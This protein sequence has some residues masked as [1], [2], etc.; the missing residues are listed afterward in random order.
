MW[1][2]TITQH[3]SNNTERSQGTC[4]LGCAA[5]SDNLCQASYKPVCKPVRFQDLSRTH[6]RIAHLD[7]RRRSEASHTFCAF[8]GVG[9]YVHELVEHLRMGRPT[10]VNEARTGV[11]NLND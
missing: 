3:F 1:Q 2:E 11:H 5:F 10:T 9:A 8:N 7:D 4:G 6:V